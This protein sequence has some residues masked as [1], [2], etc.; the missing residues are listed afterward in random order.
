[1]NELPDLPQYK[2][3]KVVGAAKI[4][5]ISYKRNDDVYVGSRPS[6]G[7]LALLTFC[8]LVLK[9][10]FTVV[11]KSA[12]AAPER[13]DSELGRKYAREDAVNQIWPLEGYLLKE[14]LYRSAE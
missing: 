12:C 4:V 11:G 2:C 1:M 9:N 6:G 14:R 5:T 10:G 13:F 3:H 8:V 7:S